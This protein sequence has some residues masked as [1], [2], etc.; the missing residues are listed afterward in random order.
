[1]AW[2]TGWTYRKSHTI[3]GS[4][5]GVQTNYQME[6]LVNR[7]S[8]SDS[9]QTVYVDTKCEA[10]FGDLRFTKADGSTVL[11]YWM[12]YSGTVA[13]CWV[14]VD[15]I[16]ASPSTV[17]IYVYY[18]KAAASTTSNIKNASWNNI[19]DDF[20]DNSR[21]A[22]IWDTLSVSGASSAETNQRLELTTAGA[23]DESGFLTTNSFTISDVE[24]QVYID[25]DAVEY[26]IIYLSLTKV[27]TT[28]INGEDDWYRHMLWNPDDEV[29]I[30][31][32]DVGSKV[33]HYNAA[34]T[35][36]AEVLKIQ[37]HNSTIKFFEVSTERYSEAWDLTSTTCYIYLANYEGQSGGTDWFDTFWIRKFVD[38]EPAHTSWGS[39][40]TEAAAGLQLIVD[41]GVIQLL[42]D[43][44]VI[45]KVV[46]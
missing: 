22:G 42:V 12:T 40:E 28:S 15:S 14:E 17:D 30:Q 38:P 1:M 44:G 2:L 29:F 35:A 25:C 26:M 20:N 7:S 4:T 6:V 32:N 5:D 16:P 24:L 36:M 34:A 19:G 21:D 27:T 11:D 23:A 33:T 41:G 46:D 43:G 45:Q 39:E 13:T 37:V 18:G 9:G 8:G 3:T 31:S 10:D